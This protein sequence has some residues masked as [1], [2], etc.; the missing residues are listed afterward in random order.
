M[1]SFSF[2]VFSLFTS[3]STLSF[4]FPFM[5]PCFVHCFPFSFCSSLCSLLFSLSLAFFPFRHCFLSFLP[6]SSLRLSFFLPSCPWI[7]ILLLRCFC[8]AFVFSSCRSFSFFRSLFLSSPTLVFLPLLF[9]LSYLSF[10]LVSFIFPS[11]FF[12]FLPPLFSFLVCLLPF[13]PF[14]IMILSLFTCL[15]P[16]LHISLSFLLSALF[17]RG[18]LCFVRFGVSS[19]LGFTYGR[20]VLPSFPSNC[21]AGG[22]CLYGTRSPSFPSPPHGA[23]GPSGSFFRTPAA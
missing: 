18:P 15:C 8:F 16:F 9:S 21:G 13:F 19:W 1:V 6:L 11:S 10:F 12:F 20:L 5:L 3:S 14:L 17:L 2:A 22:F 4:R 7:D 23:F